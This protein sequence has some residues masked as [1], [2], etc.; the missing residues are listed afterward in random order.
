MEIKEDVLVHLFC[1]IH[2]ECLQSKPRLVSLM[3]NLN[4]YSASAQNTGVAFHL[5]VFQGI[6][7]SSGKHYG[8]VY[9]KL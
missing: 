5:G 8:K 7:K 1:D 9:R 3:L 6:V 4:R 2:L